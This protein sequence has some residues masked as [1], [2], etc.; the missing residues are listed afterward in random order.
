MNAHRSQVARDENPITIGCD[1]QDFRIERTVW[2]YARSRLKV[3]WWLSSEQ[4]FPDVGVDVSVGLKADFQ[5]N[6]G[7]ASF[8]ARSKRSIMSC[9]MG[10]CALSSS[11]MQP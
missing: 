8:L 10:Y 4:P 9:G 5:A 11:K 1:L 2:N 6:R 3:Y 7:G